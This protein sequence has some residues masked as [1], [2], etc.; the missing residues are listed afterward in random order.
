M[1]IKRIKKDSVFLITTHKQKG[2]K[3][4]SLFIDLD[5]ET[6]RI[7]RMFRINK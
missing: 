1:K 5:S 7:N 2:I 6:E 3:N 4:N